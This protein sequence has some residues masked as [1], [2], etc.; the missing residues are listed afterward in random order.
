MYRKTGGRLGGKW[1]VGAAFPWGI[2]VLLLTTIG[3]KS[4]QPKTAP[5]LYIVDGERIVL[6]GS[7]GGSR[8]HPQWF[9]NLTQNPD[10]SVQIGPRVQKMRARMANPEEH[11]ALWPRFVDHYADVATYQAWTDRVIPLVILVHAPE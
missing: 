9:L 7:Q 3:R 4:G 5:L 1:R 8:N 10:V 6:V 11:A 2:P